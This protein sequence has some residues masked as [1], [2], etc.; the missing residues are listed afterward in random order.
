M[1]Y[2]RLTKIQK[3][4][5]LGIEYLNFDPTQWRGITPIGAPSAVVG[6]A[7][8]YRKTGEFIKTQGFL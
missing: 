5:L 7:I 8:L 1:K 3:K 2:A 4:I 6:L